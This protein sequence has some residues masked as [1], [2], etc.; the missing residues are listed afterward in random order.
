MRD[1]SKLKKYFTSNLVSLCFF[2]FIVFYEIGKIAKIYVEIKVKDGVDST[3]FILLFNIIGGLGSS[4]FNQKR[5][6]DLR[7]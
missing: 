6:A 1:L 3:D 2:E 7:I 4:R 5:S